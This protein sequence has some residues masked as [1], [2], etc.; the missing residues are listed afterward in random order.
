MGEDVGGA[1]NE[2]SDGR[3]APWVPVGRP[4]PRKR[5]HGGEPG[6]PPRAADLGPLDDYIGFHLQRAQEAAL[7]A[8]AA[9]LAEP[10]KAGRF[11]TLLVI[12]LNPGLS[13]SELSQAIGRD[14]STMSPLIRELVD[15]ALVV[16]DASTRD[17]RSV[18][19]RLTPK[20]EAALGRLLTRAQA[21]DSRLDKIVGDGRPELIRLLKA[22][23]AALI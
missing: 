16:R 9:T 17:R 5:R 15:E 10:Y 23:A 21:H 2:Q 8:Y 20:G 19:L 1:D 7:R 3:K 13:Q 12:R 11:P 14:K 6:P 18:H 4:R 22:I